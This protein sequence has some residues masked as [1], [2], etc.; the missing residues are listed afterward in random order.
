MAQIAAILAAVVQ[1]PLRPCHCRLHRAVRSPLCRQRCG[2]CVQRNGTRYTPRARM[3]GSPA[4]RNR[5]A[6]RQVRQTIGDADRHQFLL[7]LVEFWR[8][9]GRPITQAPLLQGRVVDLYGLVI[10]VR[11]LGGIN[12]VRNAAL[13][14]AATMRARSASLMCGGGAA[15]GAR[16]EVGCG[17]ATTDDRIACCRRCA[18]ASSSL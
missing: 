5:T 7:G 8:S 18:A 9:A 6:A 15:G 16:V 13:M 10:A 4:Q 17:T 14:A 3:C 2:R 12:A 11:D 1:Q